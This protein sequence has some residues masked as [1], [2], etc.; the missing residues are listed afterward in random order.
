MN[1]TLIDKTRCLLINSKLPRS[2][3]AKDVI[4]TCYLVNKSPFAVLKFKT[5]E[6]VWTGVPADY[7]H[8]KIFGCVAYVHVKQ[9]KLDSR[10]LKGV[11]VGYLKGVKRYKVWCGATHKC[12]ISRDVTFHEEAMLEDKDIVIFYF[13]PYT[14]KPMK[15]TAVMKDSRIEVEST[16]S[17]GRMDQDVGTT[18]NAQEKSEVDDTRTSVFELHDYQLVRD[19]VRR[20]TKPPSRYV[21]DGMIAYALNSAEDIAIEEPT[22]YREALKDS[23]NNNLIKAMEKEMDSYSLNKNKTWTLIP[24]P[25]N[26]RLV[27]CKWNFKRK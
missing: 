15:E 7:R 26:R 10:A 12:I 2:F 20:K 21:Y 5:L 24:N 9:G 18:D 11:F 8:L 3:W 25:G 4:T 17:S 14:D 23:D 19:I 22:N 16:S 27:S 1:R 6:E 13:S